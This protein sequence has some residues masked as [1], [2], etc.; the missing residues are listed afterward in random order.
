LHPLDE[1]ADEAQMKTVMLPDGEA[2]PALGQGTWMMGERPDR[3]AAEI[4]A[5]RA[6]VDLGMT[7][8]DTA[9]MYGDGAA[10]TLVGEALA[11]V[12]DTIFLVS[13]A[14][15]QNA[16]RA[17]LA[18]ACEASLRRLGTDRLDLYLL[19]WRGS[20][21]LAETVAAMEA[22]RSAGKIRHWGVSNLDGDDMAA[23]VAA[24]GK[25]CATD[26]ILY[27]LTRR[28]PEHDLLPWLAARAM[29]VMAYSPVEQGRLLASP[30]LAGVARSIGAT[31]AQVALAWTMRDGRVIAIPKAGTVAHVAENRAAADLTLEPDA[32]ALLDTAFPRPRGRQPLAML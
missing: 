6:G 1:P 11:P 30:A 12:R 17:R 25:A 16:S 23:L 21:P 22:L 29:P 18:G 9:E 31:P 4:A 7:V 14:Y 8:I 20:V 10:E 19:H 15:P 27:N 24:G 32:L 5:L 28:G 2:V 26:Q 13:K 3:R